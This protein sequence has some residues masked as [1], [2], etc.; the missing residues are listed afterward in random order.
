MASSTVP[1]WA[2]TEPPCA[3]LP[4]GRLPP[5]KATTACIEMRRTQ[6]S[7]FLRCSPDS[8]ALEPPCLFYQLPS[9]LA[10]P[11]LLQPSTHSASHHR[12]HFYTRQFTP[13]LRF[14]TLNQASATN[15]LQFAS[16][17][18]HVA[19]CHAHSTSP[20]HRNSSP[21]FVLDHCLHCCHQ[22][23]FLS[24]DS[25]IFGTP[26]LRPT[27]DLV[28]A[29]APS[30]FTSPC[31]TEHSRLTHLF[32][33]DDVMRA[34]LTG[35]TAAFALTQVVHGGWLWA[36]KPHDV[37]AEAAIHLAVFESSLDCSGAPEQS[38]FE[39]ENNFCASFRP[40]FSVRPMLWKGH[41]AA[42]IDDVN[43][44]DMYCK[45]E[46]FGEYRCPE[47]HRNTEYRFG[48]TE[49]MP[50]N[51]N[52]CLMPNREKREGPRNRDS[53]REVYDDNYLRSHPI[54]SARFVCGPIENSKHL[55]T[56]TFNVTS[57][58][59]EP[60]FYSAVPYEQEA[61]VTVTYQA[62]YTTPPPP[63]AETRARVSE[64]K[65]APRGA[66]VAADGK[67][68]D[69]WMLQPWTFGM[70]C[71][72]CYSKNGKGDKTECRMGEGFPANC[73]P[74]PT[75]IAIMEGSPEHHSTT[76]STSTRV[77]TTH[78]TGV[79]ETITYKEQ[80]YTVVDDS[81]DVSKADAHLSKRSWHTPVKFPH[82]FFPGKE[83]CADAEW[84]KR[85]QGSKQFVKLQKVHFCTH[86]D[87][88]DSIWLGPPRSV[89]HTSTA[90]ATSVLTL[91]HIST[92]TST[93]TISTT[94]VVQHDQL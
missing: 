79:D 51:F 62:T 31:V 69:V 81:T 20:S 12:E 23:C 45:L 88:S 38:P 63:P 30:A 61:T 17:P 3:C 59:I 84:E 29:P 25:F 48:F 32:Y 85:G 93:A 92:S 8:L 70:A 64:A 10:T 19:A 77:T 94:T 90:T 80:I 18:T 60:T 27:R 50:K 52:K 66:A 2:L 1:C 35:T 43:K 24:S 54:K 58:S 22:V 9:D 73:G 72:H 46:T 26:G 28:S 89:V 75:D 11:S 55:G 14:V 53:V 4:R 68:K 67:T 82:P 33:P 44:M 6:Q 40:G 13:S 91:S 21:R 7:A 78:A 39:M 57:W 56:R 41:R 42:W 36:R 15:K 83:A 71:Y 16:T 87:R 74:K 49:D 65:V 37:K 76:T 34:F 5:R 86:K 47:E